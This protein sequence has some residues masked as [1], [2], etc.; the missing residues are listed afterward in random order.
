MESNNIDTKYI[1]TSQHYNMFMRDAIAEDSVNFVYMVLFNVHLN[2]NAQTSSILFLWKRSHHNQD[3]VLRA[4]GL[5]FGT[6]VTGVPQ[7]V[8][9]KNT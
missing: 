8:S 3:S 2:L 7:R 1:F 9:K 5:Q 4:L 6:V